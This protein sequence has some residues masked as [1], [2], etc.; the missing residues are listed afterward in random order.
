M[1][2]PSKWFSIRRSEK[3]KASARI[4]TNN[5]GAHKKVYN[6][7]GKHFSGENLTR[8][9]LKWEVLVALGEIKLGRQI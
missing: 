8:Q 3:I 6:T 9:Y 1:Q 4:P 7:L 5:R 2:T